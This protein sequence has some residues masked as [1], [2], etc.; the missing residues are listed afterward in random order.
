MSTHDLLMGYLSAFTKVYWRYGPSGKFHFCVDD[1]P[2]ELEARLHSN[3]KNDL[4][5]TQQ[6]RDDELI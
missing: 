5:E 2:K 1:D 3:T 6:I 4:V